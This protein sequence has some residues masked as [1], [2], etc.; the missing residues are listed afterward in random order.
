MCYDRNVSEATSRELRDRTRTLLDRAGAGESI[1]ITVDGR[2]V[3]VLGPVTR[4]RQWMS[5]TE[6]VHRV[7]GRQ[8]DRA[9][10][11]EIRALAPDTTGDIPLL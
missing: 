5:K 9:L 11:D 3:A 1:T 7:G 4:R 6:F 8:A 10:H 2:P